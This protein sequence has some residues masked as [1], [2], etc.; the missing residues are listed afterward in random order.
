MPAYHT[1]VVDRQGGIRYHQMLVDTYDL[2]EALT[3]RAGSYR[4]VKGEKVVGRLLKLHAVSLETHGEV[5]AEHRRQEHQAALAITLI[6]SCLGRIDQS[7]DGIFGIVY[8]QAVDD[9]VGELGVL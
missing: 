7:G 5:I 6:K 8:R 3:L 9:E 2:T 1:T 4:G